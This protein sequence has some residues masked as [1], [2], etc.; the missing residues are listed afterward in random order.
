MIAWG[1][2]RPAA[3]ARLRAALAEVCVVGVRTNLGFLL[4]ALAHPDVVG[5]I[6]DTDWVETVW[7]PRVP[8]L[9]DG[10]L[11]ATD[12]DARQDPWIAFGRERGPEPDRGVSIAGGWAQYRGW[13]YELGDD[14]LEPTALA[15]PGGSL[16]APMPATVIRVDVAAGDEVNGGQVVV[17]LEAMKIQMQVTAPTAGTVRAVHVRAGDVVAGGDPLVELEET[18]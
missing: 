11:A 1:E 3:L 2:D 4:D 16:S 17:V 12:G 18:G 8:P 7:T 15:P 5:G 10:V 14:E 6:A 13:A 9:P